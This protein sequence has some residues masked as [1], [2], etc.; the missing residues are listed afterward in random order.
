MLV[1]TALDRDACAVARHVAA[2]ARSFNAQV[3]LLHVTTGTSTSHPW[4]ARV[5]RYA[6]HRF[7]ELFS[8]LEG[9]S[10]EYLIEQGS[11]EDTITRVA[12]EGNFDLV[13]LA[14]VSD[15]TFRTDIV[16]GTSYNVLCQTPC[17]ILVLKHD[18]YAAS[19]Q[20]TMMK[21]DRV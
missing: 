3:T 4:A 13:V 16:P 12:G 20:V 8:E 11:V 18:C 21:Y 15:A 5:R 10:L 14:P 2:F 19:T 7:Q 17:P 6:E 9:T 1:A